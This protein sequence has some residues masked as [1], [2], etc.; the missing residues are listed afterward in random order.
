MAKAL[1]DPSSLKRQML[2]FRALMQAL[3]VPIPK[4]GSA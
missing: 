1:N 4:D 3:F 2:T